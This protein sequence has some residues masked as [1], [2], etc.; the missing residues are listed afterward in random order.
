MIQSLTF[1]LLV[2]TAI[3]LASS[4]T[5]NADILISVSFDENSS[6]TSSSIVAG[7]SNIDVFLRFEAVDGSRGSDAGEMLTGFT[8]VMEAANSGVA[9]P[10]FAKPILATNLNSAMQAKNWTV[11]DDSAGAAPNQV[12][13]NVF[14]PAGASNSVAFDGT[15]LSLSLDT[16]G[17]IAGD[18]VVFNPDLFD[19]VAAVSNGTND[20]GGNSN[21]VFTN[22]NLNVN[23]VPEPASMVVLAFGIIPL[24]CRRRR[25]TGLPN[26]KTQ[27]VLPAGTSSSAT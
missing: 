8:Y 1:R 24:L 7:T 4:A 26:G 15:V 19:T 27:P 2:I 9:I 25:T 11:N 3:V 23:A 22:G 20:F 5:S 17:L 16:S 18:N 14:A 13:G 6:V 12:G 21:Y 10:E